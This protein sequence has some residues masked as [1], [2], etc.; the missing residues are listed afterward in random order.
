MMN[1]NR[2]IISFALLMALFTP[3]SSAFAAEMLAVAR[4]GVILRDA[5]DVKKG[6]VLWKYDKGLPLEI[7]GVQDDWRKVSDFEGDGGWLRFSDLNK[8]PHMVVRANKGTGEKTKV[9]IRK[10]PGEEYEVVGEAVYGAVFS[11]LEQ[12]LGWVKVQHEDGLE[13]WVKR[14]LLWG[15]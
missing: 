13:G 7:V 10:G 11:T 4:D 9:N 5:P 2:R 3:L 15:F 8:E 14:N 12:K 1:T 6:K